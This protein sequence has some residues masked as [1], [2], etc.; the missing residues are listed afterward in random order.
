MTIA[1]D[2]QQA[3]AGN[4]VEFF[5]IDLLPIG[6][7]EQYYFHNGVNE[8]GDDVT[9]Q[10]QVYTRFPI[11]AEGFEKNG[12]GQQPRPTLRVAN[13]TGLLGALVRDN[14]DLVR[15]KVTR[16][17][18]FLKYIDAVNFAAGNA[19]A[20]ENIFLPDEIW[21]IDRKANQN[22]I[23]I[24][25]ELASDLDLSGVLLPRRQCIQNTCTWRYRSSECGYSGDAVADINDQPVT[26][27]ADDVCGK[28]LSSCQLRFGNSTL[29]FGGFP[30]VGLI[31]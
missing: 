6:I 1:A 19:T 17:R 23:V 20:D 12:V 21:R 16:K 2:I 27:L 14:E 7:D 5:I 31:R 10:G 8:L 11:E 3:F 29:P 24:E 30:S 4:L 18:T 26:L 28:R 9:W 15:A 13:V 22:A 25:W